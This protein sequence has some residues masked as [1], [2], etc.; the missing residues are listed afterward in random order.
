MEKLEI[1][2]AVI[3]LETATVLRQGETVALPFAPFPVLIDLSDKSYLTDS[4]ALLPDSTSNFQVRTFSPSSSC[5]ISI[6][7]E[8]PGLIIHRSNVEISIHWDSRVLPDLFGKYISL[9]CVASNGAQKAGNLFRLRPKIVAP[10]PCQPQIIISPSPSN[11]EK[12]TSV[13]WFRIFM[14]LACVLGATFWLHKL[15]T[16]DPVSS[17]FEPFR[18]FTPVTPLQKFPALPVTPRLPRVSAD[19]PTTPTRR[20][21][22]VFTPYPE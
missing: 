13:D 7:E 15:R 8:S 19:E 21:N 4:L 3:N 17:S 6:H 18:K 5:D 11:L 1:S 10:E 9:N 2:V 16:H 12:E 14:A 22:P 20:M